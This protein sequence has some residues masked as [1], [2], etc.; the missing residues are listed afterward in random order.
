[1]HVHGKVHMSISWS[2]L[3]V[4]QVSQGQNWQQNMRHRVSVE[5]LII[6]LQRLPPGTPPVPSVAQGLHNLDSR[7]CAALLKDLSKVGLPHHALTI[8]EWLRSLPL[9]NDLARLCDVFT[10]TT[11]G[12]NRHQYFASMQHSFP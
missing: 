12:N 9:E 10:Y 1:M 7:A 5:D 6:I 4:M 11:G 2:L 8:F 3:L